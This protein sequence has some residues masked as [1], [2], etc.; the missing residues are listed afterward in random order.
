MARVLQSIKTSWSSV[1]HRIKAVQ[2]NIGKDDSFVPIFV[3]LKKLKLLVSG[4]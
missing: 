2:E 1:E 4:H 3:S